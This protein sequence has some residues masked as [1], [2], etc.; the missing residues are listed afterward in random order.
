MDGCPAL[1]LPMLC[2]VSHECF[3]FGRVGCLPF[4]ARR[5]ASA[6]VYFDALDVAAFRLRQVEEQV[7][8]RERRKH[9]ENN[10][11]PL[12]HRVLHEP[13][14]SVVIRIRDD[15]VLCNTVY[16]AQNKRKKNTAA[17]TVHM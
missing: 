10:E 9:H 16:T 14:T 12:L 7:N 8:E 6:Q 1:D 11:H 4:I 3:A 17:C 13:D 15:G 5:E 2:L